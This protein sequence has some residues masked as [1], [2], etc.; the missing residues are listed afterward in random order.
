MARCLHRFLDRRVL[1][2]VNKL[3]WASPRHQADPYL[4]DALRCCKDA[5]AAVGEVQAA[6]AALAQ[7]CG[8]LLLLREGQGQGLGQGLLL[9]RVERRRLY[10]LAD[11]ERCQAAHLVCGRAGCILKDGC[12]PTSC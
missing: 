11:F 6:G 5:A 7:A 1:P 8:Q 12:C 4:R 3:S 9:V 10:D 2:G